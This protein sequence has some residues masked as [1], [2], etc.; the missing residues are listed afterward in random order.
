MTDLGHELSVQGTCEDTTGADAGVSVTSGVTV[1]VAT[2]YAPDQPMIQAMD[3]YSAV[4]TDGSGNPIISPENP[5]GVV[6]DPH[7]PT[8]PVYVSQL[9]DSG[10]LVDPS[11]LTLAVTSVA[12]AA[13]ASDAGPE[14]VGHHDHHRPR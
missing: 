3:G 11:Q 14:R 13:G 10:N 6:G 12:P 8:L 9:D 5:S 7:N 1:P 2:G 4:Q